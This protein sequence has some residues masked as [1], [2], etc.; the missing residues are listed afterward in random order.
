MEKS[1]LR[2]KT[3]RDELD[4]RKEKKIKDKKEKYV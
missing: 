3:R 1:L 4:K 2:E